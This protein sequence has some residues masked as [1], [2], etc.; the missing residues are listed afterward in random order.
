MK[1]DP[2]YLKSLLE[3]VVVTYVTTFL[4]ALLGNEYGVLDLSAVKAAAA[5][6]FPA[7]LAVVYGAFAQFRGNAASALVVD[8]RPGNG[9]TGG[10]D[11]PPL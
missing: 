9:A 11:L 10:R 1:L 5:A 3:L 6:A 7:A 2:T 4:G 8:T